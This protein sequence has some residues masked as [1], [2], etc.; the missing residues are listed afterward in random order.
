M[1]KE[2]SL[3]FA[4]RNGY[5]Q[6]RATQMRREIALEYVALGSKCRRPN[7]SRSLAFYNS[8]ALT[9]ELHSRQH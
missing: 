9:I 4:E 2:P 7:T 8:S 3:G 5:I 6:T 1:H